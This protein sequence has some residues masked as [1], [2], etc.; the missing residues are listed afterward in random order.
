MSKHEKTKEKVLSG[1][2]NA[3]VGFDELCSMLRHFGFTER[4]KGSHHIFSKPGIP[5]I[6]NLQS[7]NGKAKAYQVKQVRGIIAQNDL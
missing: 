2:S 7:L 4:I 3:N 6:I 5:E 1:T